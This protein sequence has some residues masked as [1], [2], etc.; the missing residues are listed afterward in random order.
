[1]QEMVASITT[2]GLTTPLWPQS[3]LGAAFSGDRASGAYD[4]SLGKHQ[5]HW[6]LACVLCLV[7]FNEEVS[8]ITL[9]P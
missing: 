5:Q 4:W 1:M 2:S 7:G 8:L 6:D 3:T 9:K